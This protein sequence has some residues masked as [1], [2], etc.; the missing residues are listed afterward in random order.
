MSSLIVE[1]AT[2]DQINPHT[3]ADA[4]ELAIIKGWQCVVPKGKYVA[5]DRVV[6]VPVDAVMPPE[7]HEPMGITK[8]LSNGRVRCA[9]LRGEP[10]FGVVMPLADEAW[11]TGRDVAAHY[12]ITKYIPPVKLSAGD[13]AAE[14]AAFC[15][16]TDIENLRN[17]PRLIADGE[18]VV[19]T[20]K[21][22]GTNCRVGLVR[23]EWMAGSRELRRQTTSTPASN[24]YWYPTTLPEVR[25]MLESLSVGSQS[26]VLY[27]EVYGSKIQNLSYGKTGTMGFLAFDLAIDGRFVG[28]DDFKGACGAYGVPIA[29]VL[30][31]GAFSLAEVRAVSTGNSTVGGGHIREGVV[32]KPVV[33]RVDPKVGRVIL[34]YLNDDYLLQKE[35]GRVSDTCDV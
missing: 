11:E 17:F 29:P 6:Y 24:I 8:Y 35:S 3:N 32:V 1:V 9:K 7:V 21:I 30:Y 19:C 13:A 23:G 22:H 2:I 15:K 31:R 20:E 16:Y 27:G 14:D 10:S 25:A 28:F 5:G 33:E 34:K 18:E 26:V 4:L 12:G